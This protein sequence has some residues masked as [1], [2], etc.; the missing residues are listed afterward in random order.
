MAHLVEHTGA[1]AFA[2]RIA[3]TQNNAFIREIEADPE[4]IAWLEGAGLS[5]AEAARIQPAYCGIPLSLCVCGIRSTADGPL[6][7]A[8]VVSIGS[9]GL[10]HAQITAIHWQ[11]AEPSALV[12]GNYAVG[13]K[14]VTWAGEGDVGDTV[15]V[16]ANDDPSAA[17]HT[18]G[19]GILIHDGVATDFCAQSTP[20]LTKANAL[21]ALMAPN[22]S[23]DAAMVKQ[24]A[25]WAETH[26]TNNNGCSIGLGES[27]T[28]AM[29]GLIGLCAAAWVSRRLARRRVRARKARAAG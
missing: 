8:S 14:I 24:D 26:C 5:A 7:E 25:A 2:Q 15:L 20:E 11:Q 9:D 23:C 1:T 13:G 29:P 28:L 17:E 12:M 19:P 10:Q 22:D 4:L 27:A 3:A 18:V 21:A 16:Y 6:L